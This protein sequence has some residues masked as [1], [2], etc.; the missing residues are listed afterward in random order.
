MKKNIFIVTFFM[1]FSLCGKGQAVLSTQM[2]VKGFQVF[3]DLKDA[4]KFYYAPGK[5]QLHYERDGQPTF[6]LIQMR[7]TGRGVTGNQGE[8]RFM[9]IVQF[10]VIMNQ[11]AN[12][13]LA[14]I[15]K[16]LPKYAKLQPIP[17][18]NVQAILIAPFEGKYKRIG[19]GSFQ[20]E[21]KSGSSTKT[22][23]W[24]ERTFTVR[25]QNHEAQLLWDM[26][27][28][29]NI[30]MSVS[31]AYY[32]NLINDTV[33]DFEA[34]DESEELNY[35]TVAENVDGV[36]RVSASVEMA[37][38]DS[39]S[40]ADKI[41]ETI[42]EIQE[43]DTIISSTLIHTNAFGLEIDVIKYPD[44][45]VKKD[46]NEGIPP[47]YPALQVACFD[48]SNKL[49]PDLAMKTIEF[50][51]T[52]LS[53]NKVKLRAIKFLNL[54]SDLHTKQV[55]F[56]YAVNMT[57]PLRY[58]IKEFIETGD[59]IDKGWVTLDSWMG[60]LDITSQEEDIEV[61]RRT[62][63]FEVDL[64]D[65]KEN[66]ISKIELLVQYNYQDKPNDQRITFNAE[67]NLPLQQITFLADKHKPI[68]YTVFRTN[69]ERRYI[70]MKKTVAEDNYVFINFKE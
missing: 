42:K 68:K 64:E 7:Y 4:N 44:V 19:E 13:E 60:I 33:M 49:R 53:D 21:G 8:K 6:K 65:M 66:E 63:D 31:Y 43:A 16:M 10:K 57:R 58:R 9:N 23:F 47:A 26:V 37:P 40:L 34:I 35:S 70:T 14:E 28:K 27:E 69:N 11:P 15:R 32:A 50:E 52:G 30:A 3:E 41:S 22:S 2:E 25:L 20:S 5:L 24:T 61:H 55:R 17:L 46:L 38:Q 12:E 51:A 67:D 54:D 56:P 59:L 1:F 18:S 48:F 45:L 39:V 36:K 29:E 62:I